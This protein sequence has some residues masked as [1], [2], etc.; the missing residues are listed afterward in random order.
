M[1]GPCPQPS[2]MV[3]RE[4]AV[5][6]CTAG[7]LKVLKGRPEETSRSQINRDEGCGQDPIGS[8]GHSTANLHTTNYLSQ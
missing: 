5:T 8:F 6:S 4:Q 1:R 2:I 3:A 7:M